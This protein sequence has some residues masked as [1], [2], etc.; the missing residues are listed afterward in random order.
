M[1]RSKS[2]SRFML[3]MDSGMVPVSWFRPNKARLSMPS[4]PKFEGMPPVSWLLVRSRCLSPPMLTMLAGIS[5]VRALSARF[6]TVSLCRRPISSGIFPESW[7]PIRSR[8]RR[9]ERDVRLI[10]SIVLI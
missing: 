6:S 1:D 5:P 2:A 8:T 10:N 7:F 9:E 4:F 3:E